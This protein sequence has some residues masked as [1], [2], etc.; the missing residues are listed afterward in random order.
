MLKRKRLPPGFK[1]PSEMTSP[2]EL[3]EATAMA[4]DQSASQFA[5]AMYWHKDF[6]KLARLSALSQVEQDRIF[7]ELVVACIVLLMLCFE[8]PDLTVSDEMKQY[9]KELSTIMPKAHVK[10]LEGLGIKSKHLKEWKKLIE[11]RFDEYAR[12]RHDVRA[13]AMQYEGK[14]RDLELTDLSKIQLMVPL[15]AAAI[16]THHHICRSKTDGRDELFVFILNQL[17]KF[18]TEFRVH[19]QGDKITPLDR[20]RIAIH[21]LFRRLRRKGGN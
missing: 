19:M 1:D 3:A 18:Y 10:Y 17:A 6:Q 4:M 8:A 5:H 20:A 11:M 9:F 2:E 12:D 13:A 21:R 7:N 16:G 14:K 15:Q